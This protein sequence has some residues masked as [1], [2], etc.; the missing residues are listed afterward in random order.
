MCQQGRCTALAYLIL[1]LEECVDCASAQLGVGKLCIR[2]LGRQSRHRYL[3]GFILDD[4]ED[5]FETW[6]S[7]SFESQTSQIA[8]TVTGN[9][10]R[11][12][13]RTMVFRKCCHRGV[14]TA[15]TGTMAQPSELTMARR[16]RYQTRKEGDR[17]L[18]HPPN[19]HKSLKQSTPIHKHRWQALHSQTSILAVSLV[20]RKT[21]CKAL[22]RYSE[23]TLPPPPPPNRHKDR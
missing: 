15:P 18:Y 7:A 3:S 12:S 17:D 1:A 16:R 6:I 22:S 4:Q 20:T 5:A 2:I 8:V 14:R 13:Q 11:C 23:H 10:A 21:L 9:G 19:R